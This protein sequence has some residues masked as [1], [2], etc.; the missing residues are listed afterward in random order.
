MS[1]SLGHILQVLELKRQ[2]MEQDIAAINRAINIVKHQIVGI[3]ADKTNHSVS[4]V[5]NMS[6]LNK[7][8][9]WKQQKKMRFE[10]EI[11]GLLRERSD[12]ETKYQALLVQSEAVMVNHKKS[13]IQIST[14]KQAK[15]SEQRLMLWTLGS[16]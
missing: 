15:A 6:T 12:L 10:G 16:S 14:D 8:E 4:Q 1:I 7:W 5:E 9:A 2:R 3:E 13:L 11:K